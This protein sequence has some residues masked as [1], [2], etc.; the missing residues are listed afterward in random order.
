MSEQQN[1]TI[2]KKT[3]FAVIGFLLGIPVSYYFQNPM[4]QK[5]SLG[6]Y[7]QDVPKLFISLPRILFE[8]ANR[9]PMAGAERE[10]YNGIVRSLGSAIAVLL[11]TCV[12]CAFLLGAVGNYI[13]QNQRKSD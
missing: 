9:P 6:R 10:F 12:V 11:V 1:K 8:Y 7:V 4:I 13:E 3:K 5:T 2:S